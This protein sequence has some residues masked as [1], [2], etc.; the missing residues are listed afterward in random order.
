MIN[1][2]V[3]YDNDELA[4][5]LAPG[6]YVAK[7]NGLVNGISCGKL[8]L[9]ERELKMGRFPRTNILSGKSTGLLQ[10]VVLM[11][12][13]MIRKIIVIIGEY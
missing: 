9:A 12:K 2:Y 3:P 4:D 10:V 1:R 13:G 8:V 5:H 7:S 6:G 11:K